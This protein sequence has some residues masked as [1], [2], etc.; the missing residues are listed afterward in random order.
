LRKIKC[1]GNQLFHFWLIWQ[2]HKKL[3]NFVCQQNPAFKKAP[4]TKKFINRKLKEMRERVNSIK[5]ILSQ[6]GVNWL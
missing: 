4:P 3:Q 2:I 5:Q 6:K 1:S